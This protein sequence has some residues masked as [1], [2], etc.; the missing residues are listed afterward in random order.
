MLFAANSNRK[1]SASLFD[2]I[3]D[4]E[5]EDTAAPSK[6]QQ[7]LKELEQLKFDRSNKTIEALLEELQQN[8]QKVFDLYGANQI[9]YSFSTYK[10]T[11][12]YK[13]IQLLRNEIKQVAVWLY[14]ND[15]S[16]M[17]AALR[18]YFHD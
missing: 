16:T 1:I 17:P 18:Q 10:Q 9:N 12:H 15:I 8:Q 3:F 14:D 6:Q 7:L 5:P 2:E 11:V 13:N 4:H